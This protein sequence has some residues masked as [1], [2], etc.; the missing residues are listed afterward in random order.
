MPGPLATL[1]LPR[2]QPDPRGGT[3]RARVWH[4]ARASHPSVCRPA[5]HYPALPPD[6]QL[7]WQASHGPVPH[8][9]AAW[10]RRGWVGTGRDR[11][12]RPPLAPPGPQ[13][14][15]GPRPEGG[16]W[17]S[18]PGSDRPAVAAASGQELGPL[19]LPPPHMRPRRKQAPARPWA[20]AP[21]VLRGVSVTGGPGR[22]RRGGQRLVS[23]PGQACPPQPV[24][25]REGSCPPTAWPVGPGEQQSPVALTPQLSA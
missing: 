23:L 9:V 15:P 8:T 7:P 5:G 25:P 6:P 18:V 20:P 2:G 12:P 4:S 22:P 19:G 1:Q 16:H 13:T 11:G 14:G 10:A 21:A 24:Q 3:H 17:P